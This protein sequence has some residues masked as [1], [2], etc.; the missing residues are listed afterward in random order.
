MGSLSI[1]KVRRV[2]TVVVAVIGFGVWVFNTYQLPKVE[3]NADSEVAVEKPK[4]ASAALNVLDELEV[5]N[6]YIGERYYRKAFYK[7]W[8]E[9]NGCRTREV[10]LKRDL[11][12]IVMNGCK[13][14]SGVLEDP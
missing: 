3:T 13:V 7:D 8:G 4:S 10:I 2:V 11:K 1:H 12:E 6:Q 5:K 9:I 14:M